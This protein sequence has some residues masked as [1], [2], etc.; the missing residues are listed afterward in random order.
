MF[1]MIISLLPT[2]VVLLLGIGNS[3]LATGSN[4]WIARLELS[5]EQIEQIKA[6]ENSYQ[7][8]ISQLELDIQ[9]RERSLTQLIINAGSIEDLRQKE[10]ELESL[11]LEAAQVY[12]EKFLAI[13]EV[14]TPEQLLK[15]CEPFALTNEQQLQK[16]MD[17]EQ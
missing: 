2:C 11:K 6:I 14:L 3:L 1:T 4:E 17:Q 9:S 7:N 13:R 5:A 16:F 15:Q 12:F 10:R 8:S